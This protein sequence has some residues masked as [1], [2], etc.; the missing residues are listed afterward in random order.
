MQGQHDDPSLM[1]ISRRF[2]EGN[3]RRMC[4]PV[5]L[6]K[7]LIHVETCSSSRCG[8]SE[9]IPIPQTGGCELKP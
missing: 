1:G 9:N 4:V 2:F 5:G 6:K 3:T 7:Y 8:R